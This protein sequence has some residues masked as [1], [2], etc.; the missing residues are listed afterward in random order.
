MGSRKYRAI[1]L[2]EIKGIYIKVI[3]PYSE[4]GKEYKE[5]DELFITGKDQMIYFP[6]KRAHNRQI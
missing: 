5:G 4:A 2:S 6:H 3:A 1:E